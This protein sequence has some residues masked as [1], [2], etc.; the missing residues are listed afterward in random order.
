MSELCEK[1]KTPLILY[2]GEKCFKCY[3]P[4]YERIEYTNFIECLYWLEHNE[5]DFVKDIFWKF[6]DQHVNFHNG[7]Y[8]GLDNLLELL[9]PD[10]DEY[11][12]VSE[13]IKKMILVFD[14]HFPI[15]NNLFLIS[16]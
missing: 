6:T 12:E 11:D 13:E 4:V 10:T 15:S 1:C 2:H 8:I 16:W 9:D 5:K 3:K 14:K 7:D